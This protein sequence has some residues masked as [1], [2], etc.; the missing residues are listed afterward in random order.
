MNT[1]EP[2]P[3]F[4]VHGGSIVPSFPKPERLA[5]M[6]A[7]RQRVKQK[8]I[9]EVRAAVFERDHDTCRVCGRRATE[10]HELRFRSLGGAVSMENSIAV[11]HDCH[12]KLQRLHLTP[13]TSNANGH[14]IFDT[15]W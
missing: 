11:C 9:R 7:R 10:M 6:R 3:F 1:S 8:H 4:S 12:E 13:R 5:K 15:Q 2:S 14:I